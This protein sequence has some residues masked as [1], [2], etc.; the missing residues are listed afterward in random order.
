MDKDF[1]AELFVKREDI[2]PPGYDDVI[3]GFTNNPYSSP[4]QKKA[5]RAKKKAHYPSLKHGV[6][7]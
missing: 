4:K 3:A 6:D 5:A 2:R 7:S 1:W